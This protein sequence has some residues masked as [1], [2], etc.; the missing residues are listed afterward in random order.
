MHTRVRTHALL[1]TLALG[2]ALLV[3][4]AIAVMPALGA[5]P[6][7]AY[8]PGRMIDFGGW[9]VGTFQLANG[10]FVY[11]VEPG[12]IPPD[13]TQQTASVVDELRGYSVGMWDATGWSGRVSTAPISGEPL[14]RINYLLATH[15]DTQSA[16][17]A[18][19]VQF[20]IW[21]LRGGSGEQA[22]LDHH[23]T[24]VE[25]HGGASHI[26]A[27]RALV[28][29]AI[30]QATPAGPPTPAPLQMRAGSRF[31][32]GVVS[33][34][35][36]ATELR[37]SG[38]TFADGSTVLTLDGSSPGEAEWRADL[39]PSGWQRFHEVQVAGT[40]VLPS[41]GWPAE[42]EVYPSVVPNEQTLTWAVG[43]VNETHSGE[44]APVELVVDAQ[45]SPALTTRVPDR[46]I[47][48]DTEPFADTVTFSTAAGGAPW[49]A[50]TL[51][52]GSLAFAPIVA[53]GVVYGPFN[54]P[55]EPA[56]QVPLGAP[57][58]GT[59]SLIADRGPGVYSV[60]SATRPDESGYYYWVWRVREADQLAEVR[61]ADLLPAE[62][63]F[64]D[65]FGL[66]DEGHVTATRL[67]WST[68]LL[69]QELTLDRLRLE[70]RITVTLQDGAWLRD[71]A[72]ARIPARIRLS[73]YGSDTQPRQQS[74]VPVG[75]EEIA[76]GMVEVRSP[77]RSILADPIEL[78]SHT[79]GWVTVRACLVAEDQPE[80][81]RGFIE[82][83]CDDYGMPAETARIIEPAGLA[84]T[85]GANLE[86]LLLPGG[87][88]LILGTG[89]IMIAHRH[90]ARRQPVRMSYAAPLQNSQI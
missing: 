33:F 35:A 34:P 16:D 3:G 72:G 81:A 30:V 67:R 48:R 47:S 73:V 83:W 71:A 41:R 49:A 39:H 26:R 20:A 90:R 58:A 59:A 40:W 6:A 50:R 52:D 79:R 53:D 23:I 76:R 12:A 64:A 5:T 54:R 29:E 86:T 1:H 44:W 51:S 62:Y 17:T 42:L 75:A 70:D 65:D 7:T 2:I 82:E 77:G 57:I 27:A 38:G 36:G 46:W 14:R 56:A 55:Q 60:E 24:W 85:G 78:P 74:A 25:Q 15:G 63:T 43:P 11:C 10:S 19:A 13:H 4:F 31:G 32:D 84:T 61:S 68:Q 69:S 88:A 22:W 66:V 18:V 21:M 80:E 37:I 45:F 28:T 87:A 89:L 8:T 9:S